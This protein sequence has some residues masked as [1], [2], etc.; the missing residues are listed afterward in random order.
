MSPTIRGHAQV[1]E[2]SVQVMRGEVKWTGET[3]FLGINDAGQEVA[4]DWNKGPS[5]MQVCLQMVGA[6]S[7]VDVVHGLERREVKSAIVELQAERAP[8]PP[9]SFTKIHMIYKVSGNDIPQ[10][11]VERLIKSSHEK[12]CSVSNTFSDDVEITWSLELSEE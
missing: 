9:R 12:Y 8:E 5:P 3:S 4:Y 6:C 7:M 1:G 2:S 10:K 11:M